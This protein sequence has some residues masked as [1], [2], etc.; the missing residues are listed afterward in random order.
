M[1]WAKW[2]NFRRIWI[3]FALKM[4][5]CVN[6]LVKL[7]CEFANKP[8]NQ[9]SNVWSCRCV[10]FITEE[11]DTLI[12]L[13]YWSAKPM[14]GS[15]KNVVRKAE[16]LSA[17]KWKCIHMLM[18]VPGNETPA[19]Y[20]PSPQS[21]SNLYGNVRKANLAPLPEVI[22]VVCASVSFLFVSHFLSPSNTTFSI[23]ACWKHSFGLISGWPL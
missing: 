12:R 1:N 23:F 3:L 2:T 6:Y 18:K 8:N 21:E 20:E 22:L 16:I 13:G 7:R 9:S 11:V 15:L 5:F 17:W 4:K 19:L 14:P 10:Y